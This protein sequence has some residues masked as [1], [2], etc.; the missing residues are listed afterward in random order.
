MDIQL[1]SVL[2]HLHD[3]WRLAFLPHTR[4]LNPLF[5]KYFVRSI[6]DYILMRA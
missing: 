2:S 3:N 6:E 4:V 5:V 1:G